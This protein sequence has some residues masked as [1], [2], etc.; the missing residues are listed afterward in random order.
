[1][2]NRTYRYFTGQPLYPFGFG[3]S[4]TTFTYRDLQIT[5]QE[6]R[7]GDSVAIQ[8]EVENS[9]ELLGDEVVQLYLRDVEASLPVPL[10]Q[11]QGLTRIRLAPGERQTVRFTLTAEQ[12]SFVDED[13]QWVLEPGEFTVWVGGRQPDLKA[14]TQPENVLMGQ[15][16]VKS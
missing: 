2:E 9:G 12:M 15:F 6:V 5:P 1:M 10:L 14:A 4:Y 3:L 7:A 13:G 11:L 16:T 8:A